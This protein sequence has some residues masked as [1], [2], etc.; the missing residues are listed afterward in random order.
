[1]N[2]KLDQ[3]RERAGRKMAGGSG[4]SKDSAPGGV[5]AGG[6]ARSKTNMDDLNKSACTKAGNTPPL[7]IYGYHPPNE[8]RAINTAIFSRKALRSVLKL[9]TPFSLNSTT[10]NTRSNFVYACVDFSHRKLLCERGIFSVLDSEEKT[11]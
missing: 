1:M 9:F 2:K 3:K 6:R 11:R 8:E 10:Q 5:I 7:K 4:P